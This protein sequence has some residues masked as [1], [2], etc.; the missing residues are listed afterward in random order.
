MSNLI[1][2]IEFSDDKKNFTILD[3]FEQKIKYLAHCAHVSQF[4][5]DFIDKNNRVTR[6]WEIFQIS[7]VIWHFLE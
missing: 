6:L 3:V 2:S 5:A 7:V 4:S 1:I